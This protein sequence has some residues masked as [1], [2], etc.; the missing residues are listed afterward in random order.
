MT[1]R[2]NP[3]PVLWERSVFVPSAVY[4]TYEVRGH[5][6]SACDGCMFRLNH[7]EY[8]AHKTQ[9]IAVG[10]NPEGNTLCSTHPC[11]RGTWV[12]DTDAAALRLE[13]P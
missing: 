12:K 10:F 8:E 7:P 1:S 9:A 5:I 4:V 11:G 13:A 6:D 2:T 3:T